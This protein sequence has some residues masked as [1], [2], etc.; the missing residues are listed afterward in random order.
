MLGPV[1]VEVE[2]PVDDRVEQLDVVAD[3][4]EAALVAAQ[5]VAQPPDRVGVEVVRRLVEQ[6]R[7]RAGEEDAGQ[8]DPAPLAAREGV[9]RLVE[10]P[11]VEAEVGAIRAASDSAA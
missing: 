5:E 9:Q 10:D 2:D 4:H 7:R 3:D 1:G 8:L 11:V 6:Q